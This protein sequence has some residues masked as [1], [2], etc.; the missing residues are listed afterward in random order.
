MSGERQKHTEIETGTQTRAGIEIGTQT[1]IY[2]GIQR[3]RPGDRER[4]QA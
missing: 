1:Q 3:Y 4:S 2:T